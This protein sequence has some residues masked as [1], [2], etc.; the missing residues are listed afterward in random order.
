[1]SNGANSVLNAG[2]NCATI[3][4][5]VSD[6]Y[7]LLH[8]IEKLEQHII[9]DRREVLRKELATLEDGFQLTRTYEKRVR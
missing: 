3:T 2:K 6:F 9:T 7:A 1:M 5:N 8:R 4:I